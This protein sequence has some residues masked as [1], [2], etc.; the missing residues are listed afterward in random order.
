[1]IFM[2]AVLGRIDPTIP[3]LLFI[4]SIGLVI[5]ERWLRREIGKWRSPLR[6]EAERN[7]QAFEDWKA[8]HYPEQPVSLETL[9]E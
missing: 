2:V 7:R 3:G 9:F 1:M 4:G 8:R 6:R 5:L